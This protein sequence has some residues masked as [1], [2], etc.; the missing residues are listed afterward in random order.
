M[1]EKSKEKDPVEK[2]QKENF[3]NPNKSNTEKLKRILSVPLF[4]SEL[5][6]KN[7]K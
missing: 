7:S 1:S 6:G 3:K 2:I 4:F 5:I